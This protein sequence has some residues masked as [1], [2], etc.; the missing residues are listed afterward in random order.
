MTPFSAI[1]FF[2]TV[3]SVLAFTAALIYFA[4]RGV[5]DLRRMLAIGERYKRDMN[6]SAREVDRI[7]EQRKGD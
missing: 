4:A 7:F 6:M 3:A 1:G 2:Y 5:R